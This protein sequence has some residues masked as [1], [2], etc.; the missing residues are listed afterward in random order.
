M[1]KGSLIMLVSTTYPGT[2]EEIIAKSFQTK[3]F[4]IGKDIFIAYTP[5]RIDPSNSKF[6]IGICDYTCSYG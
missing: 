6:N 2:T 4:S 3:G 1:K 5:E